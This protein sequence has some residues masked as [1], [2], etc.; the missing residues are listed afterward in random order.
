MSDNGRSTAPPEP[1]NANGICWLPAGLSEHVRTRR[2]DIFEHAVLATLCFYADAGGYT[3]KIT[4]LVLS[5][6]FRDYTMR[7]A[8]RVLESLRAKGYI[9][10]DPNTKEYEVQVAFIQA[11]LPPEDLAAH[12]LEDAV[13]DQEP[14]V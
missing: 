8:K 3:G 5:R 1:N 12:M 10:Y 14:D 4:P 6:S 13:A 11:D 9:T 7:Q 2:I